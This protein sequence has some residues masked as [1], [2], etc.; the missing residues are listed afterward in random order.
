M[1]NTRKKTLSVGSPIYMAPEVINRMYDY[2]AD[3]WSIGIMTYILLTGKAPFDGK[4]DSEI[5]TKIRYFSYNQDDL[6][7]YLKDGKY[8]K[9][10]LK[11]CLN[12]NPN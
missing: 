9:D 7:V 12:R 6:D 2:K 4:E 8:V 1:E 10:F 11:R 3:I 5:F